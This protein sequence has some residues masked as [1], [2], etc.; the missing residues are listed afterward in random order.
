M[1]AKSLQLLFMKTQI[2]FAIVTGMSAVSLLTSCGLKK[3]KETMSPPVNVTVMAVSANGVNTESKYSGT[4]TE[5]NASEISFSVPGT[6]KAIYVSEG[7]QVR[8][9]QLL[10][11]VKAENLENAYNIAN[12]TLA[13]AQDAYNRFKQLHDA[14]ALADIKWVEVQNTLKA[15]ENSAAIARRALDD[16]HIYSPVSGTIAEK[17]VDVGQ[18]VV[19]A[20]PVMRVVALNDV[21]V[22]IPV[23][24]DE[25]ASMTE[26]M[27]AEIV[28]DALNGRTIKGKLSE[29]GITANPLT[30]AYDVK[31]SV[32][33]PGGKLLPGMICSVTLVARSDSASAIVLP[34]QSVLL[35]ADNRNFVWIAKDG[36]A[37]RK[38]VQQKGLVPNGIV[39][40]TG[41]EAGD[42]VIIAGMQKVSEGTAVNPL[43]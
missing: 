5:G 7:Q 38:F 35:T 39:I 28:V 42:S 10:A 34:P 30:R 23:P 14:N 24:E 27:D 19:P 29:K 26:G 12:A 43:I 25:I 41:L 16:A 4:V 33:N 37:T 17:M 3:E 21:K 9:G 11:E 2:I 20:I 1:N 15:A 13:E 6:I 22:S 31:F 32:D 18:T 36:K 40:G 8:K